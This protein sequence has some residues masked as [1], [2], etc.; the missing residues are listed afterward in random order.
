MKTNVIAIMNQKGGVGKTTTSITL[1]DMLAQ[2]DHKVL[3]IDADSQANASQFYG[4]FGDDYN[5]LSAVLKG[6]VSD[7]EDVFYETRYE[8][9]YIVPGAMELAECDIAA[10]KGDGNVRA[11]KDLIDAV[12]EEIDIDYC[13]IDCPPCFTA[14]SVSALY[15][16]DE[17]IIPTTPDINAISGMAAINQQISAVRENIRDIK[18]RVL[19]T[20]K[21]ST[22]ED[23]A[24]ADEL[25]ESSLPV[26]DTPIRWSAKVQG[27]MNERK[28]LREY[29]PNCIATRCYGQLLV[30]LVNDGW[31]I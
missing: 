15:A 19:I 25:W 30:E 27:A 22:K 29:S 5:N 17:V 1:A 3:I 2:F 24:V 13:I 4:I 9:V 16:A 23:N 7:T 28:T 14:A 8:G 10:I 11:I 6:F 21:R 18:T 31:R 12:N 20:A 26:C